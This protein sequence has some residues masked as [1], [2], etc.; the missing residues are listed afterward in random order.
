LIF[1]LPRNSQRRELVFNAF[2]HFI[3]FPTGK[4]ISRN[5]LYFN[6]DRCRLKSFDCQTFWGK[7]G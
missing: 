5:N 6:L 2:S 4:N 1:S 3:P 7:I